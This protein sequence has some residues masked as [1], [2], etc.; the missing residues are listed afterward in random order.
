MIVLQ[1]IE[2]IASNSAAKA[3]EGSATPVDHKAGSGILVVGKWATGLQPLSHGLLREHHSAATNDIFNGVGVFDL[4]DVCFLDGHGACP[5]LS[6]GVILSR[7]TEVIR[8]G[9][10]MCT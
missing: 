5:S 7:R 8:R 1:E 2:D 6:C 4:F 10:L 9:W 3:P